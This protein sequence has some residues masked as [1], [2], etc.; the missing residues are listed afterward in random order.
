ME[1]LMKGFPNLHKNGG[2]IRGKDSVRVE[3]VVSVK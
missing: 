3:S 1:S 2:L